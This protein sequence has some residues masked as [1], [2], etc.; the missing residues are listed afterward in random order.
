[1]GTKLSR[2]TNR[3]LEKVVSIINSNIPDEWDKLGLRGAYGGTGV[4]THNEGKD[5][6]GLGTTGETM[7]WLRGFQEGM[8]LGRKLGK[9]E[10]LLEM[11]KETEALNAD[12]AS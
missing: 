12:N 9:N 2:V 8:S 3:D 7:N 4:D 6:S 5:L 1:M 11:V 10:T